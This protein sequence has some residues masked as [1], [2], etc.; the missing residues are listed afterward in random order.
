[1]LIALARLLAG[2]VAL[3][4]IVWGTAALWIDGPASRPLAAVLAGGFALA[5]LAVLFGVRAWTRKAALLALLLGGVVAWWNAIPA[6]NERDWQPDVAELP[7]A[8]IDGSR[9]TIHNVR[10]FEYRSET[11]FTERWETRTYDLDQLTGADMF[12][13]YWGPTAIA[14]TIA[15]W[16]F[17]DGQHLA[18][19]IETRKEKGETYSALLGF[20]RQY[21][22]YYVVADERDVIGVRTNHRGEHT[23][24]YRLRTPPD[25]AR[26]IL[27]DYLA[28]VNR[29]K[30]RPRWYNALTHNCTTT[31]RSHAQHVSAGSPFAWQL[32]LNGHLDE[33]GY[34]R[35]S[36]NTTL[37]F[38]ELRARSEITERAKAAG[39]DPAFSARLR[40]GLPARPEP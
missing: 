33:L 17:A 29:L 40:E 36:I 28:E 38:A 14:H 2:A 26:A 37:P 34:E 21:E 8:E 30:E 16:D 31:I 5:A 25:V 18:V 1:M 3:P 22:I 27:L 35:G 39:S 24:L 6:S 4:L 7:W 15:S 11:D 23:Y 9:V 13:S 10:N 20:F 19:S 32:L 12:L